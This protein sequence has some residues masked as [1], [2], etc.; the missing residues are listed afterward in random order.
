[1]RIT[2]PKDIGLLVRDARQVRKMS[3]AE[4]AQRVGVSR[5]WVVALE[6]G[7]SGSG[8]GAVL[9]ALGAVGLEASVNPASSASTSAVDLDDL[10]E[11]VRRQQR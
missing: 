1:M 2:T 4:L 5:A 10:L 6:Q 3:Q 7:R 8:I 9:R 11:S